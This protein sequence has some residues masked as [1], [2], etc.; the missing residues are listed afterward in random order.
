MNKKTLFHWYVLIPGLTGFLIAM[1]ISWSRWPAP[2][3]HDDFGNLLVASTLLEGRLSNPVPEAWESMETFH[4]VFQPSYASK[5]P[6]G[7]GFM[8][9]VGKLIFGT[10]AAGLWLCSGLASAAIAWMIAA[11]FPRR[12][13]MASGLATA[14]HPF[15]QNGWSQEFTNGWLAVTGTALVLGGLLRI[16]SRFRRPSTAHKLLNNGALHRSSTTRKLVNNLPS[17]LSCASCDVS[18]KPSQGQCNEKDYEATLTVIVG[19]GCIITL[20]SRPFEG[21]LVCGLLGLDFLP[22]LI[23]RQ[24]Y[25]DRRFWK[26][27]LPGAFILAAGIGF[28]LIINRSIT[29]QVTQLP[30]QLHESQYGVAPVLIWQ[31]PHEP[32][33]GHRFTEQVVF[34]RGW[35]MNAYNQTASF[36]GYFTMLHQRMVFLVHHWGQM[37][38]CAP[39][40]LLFLRPER[41]RLIGLIGLLLVAIL[42]INCI[43]WA[44]PQYVSP[45]IPIA[46]FIG[47]SVSRGFI[48]RVGLSLRISNRPIRLEYAAFAFVL[49]LNTLGVLSI[50]YARSA[51]S[52]GWEVSW[53]EKRVEIIRQLESHPQ[54]DLVFVRYPANFDI[55]N[56]EWVFNDADIENTPVLWVRWGTTELNQRVTSAYPNR[57]V[58]LLQFNEKSEPMLSEFGL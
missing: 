50:A 21:G 42:V 9:A 18:F 11:H 57:K 16:R 47:C 5:Y 3:M 26:A 43:P 58:W 25:L 32:S 56:S 38:A 24:V 51:R 39:L 52:E 36:S 37:L 7:L 13:A 46:I 44:V 54:Q 22:V 20:F 33:I 31:K 19:L 15:W 12:W 41:R 53:A 34:H 27:A 55:V 29:G 6:I 45:L 49:L 28:Q 48:K 10:F 8:L 4:V 17:S 35:S 2:S 40:G 23:R 1:A 14:T 30:Y